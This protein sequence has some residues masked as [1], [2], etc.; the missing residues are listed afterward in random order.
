MS[1][2]NQALFIV[3]TFALMAFLIFS[4][5]WSKGPGLLLLIFAVMVIFLASF[6]YP[7]PAFIALIVLRTASDFLTDTEIF[8]LGHLSVNFTSLVGAVALIFAAVVF[9]RNKAW[10]EKIPLL[11]NWVIWLGLALVLIM[12]SLSPAVSLTEYLRW[13]SFFSLFILGFC[14]FRNGRQTT[15]LLKT[16]VFSSLIPTAVALWQALSGQ[17][18]FDGERWRVSGTFTHPNMLAFYLV[19]VITLTLF[20]FLTLRKET[21]QKYFYLLLS[22]PLI[23]ALILTYTRGAWVALLVVIF[24]IGLARYRLFLIS[25]LGLAFILYALFLPFQERASSLISF[26]ASDSTVWRLDLWRDAWG[27]AQNN[28]LLGT[29]PGTAP[30]VIAANRPPDLGSSE[31]HNDYIKVILETGL[32]GLAIYVTLIAA[33]FWHLWRGFRLEKLPR[34]RLLFLFMLI[35]SVGL[36]LASIG[37]NILKDSSLQWS[38]WSLIGALMYSYSCLR[39]DKSDLATQ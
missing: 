5:F 39:T 23:T 12:S 4:L 7:R 9:F 35:F 8:S 31:P 37:D 15:L 26:S 17:E 32:V 38:F 3:F 27:Y 10:Q 30:L 28:L 14:L 33:L 36:Y 24:L 29:G 22:L 1:N 21:V 11:F 18:F 25:V 20:V 16:L 6:F 34:R 13:S 19:F 2:K